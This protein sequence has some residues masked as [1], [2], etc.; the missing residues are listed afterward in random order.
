M[1]LLLL[2][3]LLHL[4]YQVPDQVP[5]LALHL[6]CLPLVRVVELQQVLDLADIRQ[7][8]PQQLHRARLLLL[9]LLLLALA[10]LLVAL[11]HPDLLTVWPPKD[12]E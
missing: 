5:G 1:L 6:D 10:L 3:L 2:L 4:L 11:R 9:A 12:A 7:G 8:A